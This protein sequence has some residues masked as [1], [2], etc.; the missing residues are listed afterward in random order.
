V[1][2]QKLLLEQA[3]SLV[4]SSSSYQLYGLALLVVRLAS[5]GMDLLGLLCLGLG[6]VVPLLMEPVLLAQLLV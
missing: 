6:V 5:L 3:A 4:A 1:P 2:S